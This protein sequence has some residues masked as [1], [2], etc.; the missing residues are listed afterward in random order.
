MQ[1][2]CYFF[3]K[4]D[5]ETCQHLRNILMCFGEKSGL[6]PN[7]QKSEIKFSPNTP[8]RFKKIMARRFNCKVAGQLGKCLGSTIDT[9]KRD[10]SVFHIIKDKL[11]AKLQGWKANMLSQA[12]RLTLI[13]SVLTQVPLLSSLLLQAN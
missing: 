10:R 5:L 4:S 7:G 2:I 6:C 12:G 3:L 11:G 1:M 8:E 13:K 9:P